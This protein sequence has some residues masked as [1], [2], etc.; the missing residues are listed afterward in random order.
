MKNVL[1]SFSR[2]MWLSNV[3]EGWLMFRSHMSK[4]KVTYTS[5]FAVM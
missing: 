2:D 1:N 4:N 3:T 5:D